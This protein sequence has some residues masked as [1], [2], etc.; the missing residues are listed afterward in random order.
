MRKSIVEP[1]LIVEPFGTPSECHLFRGRL[2]SFGE[3]GSLARL[4]YDTTSFLVLLEWDCAWTE[5]TD[6]PDEYGNPSLPGPHR[7]HYLS[8]GT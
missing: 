8:T 1:I 4:T 6:H 5:L 3:V 7:N 2:S